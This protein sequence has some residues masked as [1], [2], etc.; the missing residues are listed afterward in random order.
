VRNASLALSDAAVG[1]HRDCAIKFN[2]AEDP[3]DLEEA[4][5]LYDRA[6]TNLTGVVKARSEDS[7]GQFEFIESHSCVFKGQRF[8]HVVLKHRGR[9]V[10]LLIAERGQDEKD[11][12]AGR[13]APTDNERGEVIACSSS[14][15]FQVSCFETPRHAVFVVSDLR[16]SENLAVARAFAPTLLEHIARS[17]NAA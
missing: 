12:R 3:I 16:E 5:R 2:L 15:Q 11:A 17:E 4:G 8:A 7:A 10:S 1:D 9:V 13:A 6:F 14:G